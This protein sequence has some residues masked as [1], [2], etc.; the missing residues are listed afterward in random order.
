MEARLEHTCASCV[1]LALYSFGLFIWYICLVKL[2]CY[3]CKGSAFCWS[4]LEVLHWKMH[5]WT[6]W[7]LKLELRQSPQNSLL[8]N[9]QQAVFVC[10]F[11]MY[12]HLFVSVVHFAIVENE[13]GVFSSWK[14]YLKCISYCI[15]NEGFSGVHKQSEFWFAG[16]YKHH[17]AEW[18]IF[19][20]NSNPVCWICGMSEINDWKGCSLH[21]LERNTK[22]KRSLDHRPILV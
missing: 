8:T 20:V 22:K 9:C 18:K 15:M 10:L 19:H 6:W 21:V 1:V 4:V 17:W 7:N 5:G 3:A 2:V 16:L 12:L 14:L 13:Y 11:F